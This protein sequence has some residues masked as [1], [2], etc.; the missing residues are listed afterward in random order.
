MATLRQIRN[1]VNAS[2]GLVNSVAFSPTGSV[3]GSQGNDGT[4]RLWEMATGQQAALP[5]TRVPRWLSG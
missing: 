3:L 4:V 1:P 5:L 2:T